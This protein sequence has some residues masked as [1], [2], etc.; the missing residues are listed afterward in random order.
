[1]KVL[2]LNGSSRP[3][4]CT[5]TAL[6]EVAAAL[7]SAGIETEILFLGSGPV[8]DCIACEA[9]KKSPGRCAIDDDF[10]NDII[11]KARE[12]DGLVLG[13]PVYFSHPSGRILSVLD[14][15]FYAGRPVF[16]HKPAAAIVSAR[17]AGTSSSLDVLN[18]Y[19]T[20]AQMPVVSSTYWPMVH[21][22]QPEEVMQ[23]AEGLRT[24]RNLAANMAWLLRCI[25]AGKAAGFDAPQAETGVQT[26][27]IR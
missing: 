18:K 6:A 12:A 24:M 25:E 22:N 1:M 21:G 20:V 17:R 15:V 9:C 8:R 27:F 7:N 16:A 3:N 5:Y 19:F 4:G 23:D 26:N 11:D 14:R 10:I 13:S 2:L